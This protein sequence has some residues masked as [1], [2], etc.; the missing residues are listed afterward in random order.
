MV[1][2]LCAMTS[3][4]SAVLIATL[5]VLAACGSSAQ[6][7]AIR[8]PDPERRGPQGRL[9]QFVVQCDPSHAA[10]DDPLVLPWQPGKSHLHLF[11]GNNAVDSNPVYDD[12]LLNAG[13][14]CEQRRDTASYWAPALLDPMGSTIEPIS[15][16]AYYRPGQGV[17]YEQIVAYPEGLML[18]GVSSLELFDDIFIAVNCT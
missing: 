16:T 8:D 11:F 12:R 18:I 17:D 13:T 5:L 10:F 9:A 2:T 4:R 3:F 15:M 7:G 6:P 14:S 1:S